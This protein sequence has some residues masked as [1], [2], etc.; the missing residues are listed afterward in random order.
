MLVQ[1]DWWLDLLLHSNIPQGDGT[2]FAPYRQHLWPF[3][4]RASGW[5][6]ASGM[7]NC[8]ELL[9]G[10]DVPHQNATLDD[11]GQSLTVQIEDGSLYGPP[12]GIERQRKQ[13]ACC[14]T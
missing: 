8:F 1:S 6:N 7:S 11:R 9:A 3:G 13:F 5:S 2:V 10:F 4:F 12:L 14:D